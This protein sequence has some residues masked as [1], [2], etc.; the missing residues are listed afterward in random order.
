MLA[1]AVSPGT[2]AASEATLADQIFAPIPE[3][4]PM[5]AITS[6][7][8]AQTTTRE[9]SRA[10]V[11]EWRRNHVPLLTTLADMAARNRVGPGAP[12]PTAAGVGA[13]A[14]AA[15]TGI[16]FACSHYRRGTSLDDVAEFAGPRGP[17]RPALAAELHPLHVVMNPTGAEI[18]A[19]VFDAISA[20]A[21]LRPR[22]AL[23]ELVIWFVGHGSVTDMSGTDH[24][25]IDYSE[26]LG[27][28][29]LARDVGVHLVLVADTCNAGQA[30]VVAEGDH[31]RQLHAA[32]LALPEPTRAELL[33]K[34]DRIRQVANA[35]SRLGGSLGYLHD[36]EMGWGHDPSSVRG[37]M[38]ER[39]YEAA[40]DLAATASLD[41][42]LFPGLHDLFD[43][44][45]DLADVLYPGVAHPTGPLAARARHL[46]APL[47][48]RITDI[49]EQGLRR[50][51]VEVERAHGA[52]G[53]DQPVTRAPA[54]AAPTSG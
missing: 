21:A 10:A 3:V 30:V 1:A 39:A 33:A 31:H 4:P 23:V 37:G 48:D 22:G 17:L 35:R 6:T 18:R 15:R 51:D 9:L 53:A 42:P 38:F 41:D 46:G 25:R 27:W 2:D 5:T 11:R 49:S 54:N 34:H 8:E 12:L 13:A 20:A 40:A 44:L 7:T 26:V 28:Q 24:G 19:G 16:V 45:A 47:L 36:L 32:I 29:L 50:L 52:T 14:Y 43:R